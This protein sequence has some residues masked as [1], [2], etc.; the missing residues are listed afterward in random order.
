MALNAWIQPKFLANHLGKKLVNLTS[1][2]FNVGLIATSGLAARSVT[3]G[4]EF[5]SDL[6]ANN[7]SALTEVSGGGYS[8][9]GLTSVSWSLSGLVNELT[10]ANP[11]WNPATFNTY[12]AWIHDETASSGTDATRPLL[13][14]YDLGGEQS[15]SGVPFELVV[16]ASGLWQNAASQ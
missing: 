9:Q 3:E 10:A 15:P 16:N 14:I 1:D 6:L 2:T 8:R 12:Y 11:E 7:G 5:V 4:Y 13:F